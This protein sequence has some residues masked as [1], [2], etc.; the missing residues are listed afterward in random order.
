MHR[1]SCLVLVMAAITAWNTVYLHAAIQSLRES[2][3]DVPDELLAH[4]SPNGWEHLN[5]LGRY[6]FEQTGHSLDHLRPLRSQADMSIDEF[7]EE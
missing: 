5:F 1:A 2:G 4:I 6:T 7:D 3:V